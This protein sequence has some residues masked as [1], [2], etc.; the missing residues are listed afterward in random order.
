[1]EITDKLFLLRSE[2][3][4]AKNRHADHCIFEKV[5]NVRYLHEIGRD[6]AFYNKE[7]KMYFQDPFSLSQAYEI[8]TVDFFVKASSRLS[9]AEEYIRRINYRYDR[10]Q[11]KVNIEGTVLDILNKEELKKRWI[12]LK[13]SILKDYKGAVVEYM[14]C[15]K[16]TN[17]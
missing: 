5:L 4:D 7:L 6:A 16:S 14:G 12:R 13:A 1:M 11:V 15:Q 8:E 2:L 10:I 9:K 3:G 17:N